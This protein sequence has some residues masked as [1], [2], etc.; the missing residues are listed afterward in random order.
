[1]TLVLIIQV[2]YETKAAR[3]QATRVEVS[4]GIVLYTVKE[5]L[6]NLLVCLGKAFRINNLTCIQA[7]CS[8]WS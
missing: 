7:R 1:M 4:L 5:P 2:S 8:Q 3:V 6:G